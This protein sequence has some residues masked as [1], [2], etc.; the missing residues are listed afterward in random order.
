MDL[1]RYVEA[2]LRLQLLHKFIFRINARYGGYFWFLIGGGIG[3]VWSAILLNIALTDNTQQNIASN[4]VAKNLVTAADNIQL[5]SDNT[6]NTQSD[7]VP[8]TNEPLQQRAELHDVGQK[9]KDVEIIKPVANDIYKTVKIS[10]G[11]RLIDILLANGLDNKQAMAVVEALQRIYDPRKLRVGQV[12]NFHIW[13][14]DKTV[15]LRN[16]LVKLSPL[17]E[18]H[19]KFQDTKFIANKVSV[20]TSK[21]MVRAGGTINSSFYQAAAD[22]GLSAQLIV[23]LTKIFSYDV[24]FQRDIRP[25]QRLD[26]LFEELVD[27]SGDSLL[28]Q[29]IKYAALHIG[30]KKIE[31]YH[32][33]D[34][35][36][37]V[38]YYHPNGE[39]I[40][41]A[42]IKTPVNGARISSGFGM[43]RHPVL[44]YSR[45]HK[46]ID[47]AAPR[48][49]PVYAAGDGI[50]QKAKRNG[51]YGN[52]IKIRHNGTY[53]TAYAHLQRFAKGI[54]PGKR[55]KQ[56]DVIAY[57]GSTGRSTG[58][59]LHYEILKHNKQ[60]NPRKVKFRTGRVLR[61]TELAAFRKHRDFVNRKFAELSQIKTQ[62][63]M[64]EK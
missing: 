27:E 59:H 45:V 25:G 36:G 9:G 37:T 53:S 19:I 23:K 32:Y 62:V 11:D 12:I 41:K 63:A 61:G 33:R 2:L 46:G 54:R 39:S 31:I 7:V 17:Q 26:V 49:T 29:D 16:L 10:A 56:G 43:R 60:V 4:L 51:G 20:P 35:S 30:G 40:R 38:D 42:L 13:R 34:K 28:Q 47:F 21:I 5:V 55:V 57:V 48:G 18:I 24:D 6:H 58:P 3:F 15:Q 1:K 64:V 22:A 44:G 14:D 50:I 8:D 52:Y